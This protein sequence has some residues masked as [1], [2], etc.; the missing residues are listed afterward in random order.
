MPS[1]IKI[2]SQT[3]NDFKRIQ[4]D[5]YDKQSLVGSD[6]KAKTYKDLGNDITT[7]ENLSFA[8]DKATRYASAGTEAIRKID[9]IFNSL[10]DILQTAQNFKKSLQLENSSSASVNDLTRAARAGLD[11]VQGSL[12]TREG[13]QFI[14]GGS[15]TDVE[16]VQDLN[17]KSNIINGTPTANY[18]NGDDYKFKVAVNSTLNVEYGIT[19]ADDSFKNLIA[20]FNFAKNVEANGGS[21]KTE[22]ANA[23][24][25]LDK[26]IDGII[27]LR[28]TIGANQEIAKQATEMQE[29]TRDTLQKTLGEINSPDIVALS[30]E[31][32]S[33]QASL[34]ATFQ[35]FTSISRLRLTDYI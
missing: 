18:Y 3:I 34:T 13:A 9:S 10:G 35:N 33:L 5:L 27:N 19:A 4:T 16:P 17:A 2:F 1:S 30:I 28:A 22:L 12:N 15:K 32:S 8:T 25:L 14:F 6:S 23:S 21:N 20:A 11:S 29:R 31:I 7:V 24:N 26:A